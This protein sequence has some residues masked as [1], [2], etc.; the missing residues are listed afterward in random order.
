MILFKKRFF[1]LLGTLLFLYFTGV[2][3]L[4][5]NKEDGGDYFIS[6][7]Y[8]RPIAPVILTFQYYPLSKREKE[9]IKKVNPFGF[10]L[11]EYEF[12]NGVDPVSLKKEVQELL[13]RENVYFFIDQEGGTVDRLKGLY[14]KN[15][16]PSARS[17]EPLARKDLSKAK[18]EVYNYGF[19]VGRDL[20]KSGFDVNFAPNSEIARKDGRGFMD[21]R[22]FSTDPLI[23]KELSDSYAEG[24]MAAGI[25]PCYKHAPGI[26]SGV[27]D[28]HNKGLSIVKKSLRT[29]KEK[30]LVP[31]ENANKYKYLMIANGIY[32]AIDQNISTYSPKFYDFIRKELNFSGLI[33]TDAL[34]MSSAQNGFDTGERMRM[35]I[36]AGADIV[37]PFYSLSDSFDKCLEDI[38]KIPPKKVARFNRKL[39]KMKLDSGFL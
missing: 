36:E 29:L 13:G 2:H 1:I 38:K 32:P 18:E 30:Q 37:T 31:F 33:I 17:F 16:Y 10:V 19:R 4:I 6:Q 27:T 9:F 22:C 12:I 21:S 35:A 39:K 8:K 25:E 24:L 20:K 28:P 7:E 5:Q 23:A 26:A 15:N 14:P 3:F 34:N 11:F